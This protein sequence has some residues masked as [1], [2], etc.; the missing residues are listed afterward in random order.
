MADEF[1]GLKRPVGRDRD[2]RKLKTP[3]QPKLERRFLIWGCADGRSFASIGK[4]KFRLCGP[5][6]RCRLCDNPVNLR[7]PVEFDLRRRPL[8]R[9]K[10][11]AVIPP[12]APLLLFPRP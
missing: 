4:D 1:G 3:L 11:A 8:P 12:L 10:H 9:S 5:A 6:S 2:D 7:V